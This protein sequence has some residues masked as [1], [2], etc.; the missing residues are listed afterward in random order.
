MQAWIQKYIGP[1]S[2]YKRCA[3]VAI[4]LALQQMLSSAMGIVD[5]MMV[6]WINQVTAVGTATQIDTLCSMIC[7]GAIGG[8]GIFSSQFY[9]AGDHKNL[10]RTFGLSV[11]L[12]L[13]NAIFW[14]FAALFFGRAIL[15]FYMQDE[16]IIEVGMQYL[17]IA[18]WSMIPSCIQFSFSYIYRSIHKATITLKVSIFCMLLNA[19]L[20]YMFIFG[21]GPFP[22]MGVRGAALGTLIAQWTCVLIYF[23]HATYTKQPFIGTFQEMFHLE[24]SFV[25]PI[26]K[27]IYPLIINETLFGFGSTLFVK[28][29]GQL[30]KDSMDAYYVSNQIANVFLFVVYGYGNAITVLLGST[31]GKGK[32]K[33]AI[34]EGN[35]YAGLSFIIAVILVIS[36]IIFTVPMVSIFQLENDVAYQL[37]IGI[38]IVQAIKIS[39][40]LYNFMIFSVLRAGGDS[41]IISLL[42][43]GIMWTIGIPLAFLC[44]NVFHMQNIALVFLIVQLE[45]F[46]RMIIGMKRFFSG[47]WA[48]DLTSLVGQS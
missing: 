48:K 33:D 5:S 18:M 23:T 17:Q 26:L 24:K 1:K 30:G 44:V 45:Q 39:M 20:N 22:E 36:M 3:H 9:G 27:K 2:F 12:A 11:L 37:A 35:Y 14:V 40:R 29:F 15:L 19:C 32:I 42:D 13:V 43:S 38:M 47:I 8:T 7:Y 34:Q 16:A 46:L 6:S 25:L 4:P 41:K 28:A 31:L 10:K 21:I